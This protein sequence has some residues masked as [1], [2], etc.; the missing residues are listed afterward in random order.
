MSKLLV[1]FGA[2]GRQGGSVIKCVLSDPVLSKEYKIRGV[3]RDLGKPAVQALQ[4]DGVEVV[5]ADVD[6]KPSLVKAMQGAH[7]VFGV[8]V[9]V[10][11]N[12][13]KEREIRQGKALA[14]AAVAADV[15]YLIFSSLA[16]PGS[17]SG[18]KYKNVSHFESK[19]EVEQYIRGLPI[20]SAFFAPGSFMQNF[21]ET[22]APQPTGDGNFAI[23][24]CITPQTQ[25]P[26]IDIAE[27]TGKWVSA[28]LAEP[29]KYEGKYLACAIKLYSMEEIAEIISKISGK[30]V[31]YNQ[32]PES[33]FRGFLLPPMADGLVD[34]LLYFQDFGYYGPKTKEQVEWAS[35]NARGKLTTLEEY[36]TKNPLA[37]A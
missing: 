7:A 34:M 30:T 17:I 15:E 18:G 6:D 20:K 16:H 3:T 8:T 33:V 24:N 35:Q 10:Y 22:M 2:T 21:K 23:F 9:T 36:L 13:A 1:V 37:L 14:D 26:L 19:A 28:I 31:K 5:V 29:E 12:Q 11:D 27:D 25:L 4:N 32:V